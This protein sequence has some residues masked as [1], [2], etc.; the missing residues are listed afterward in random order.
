MPLEQ[1]LTTG[2]DLTFAL[3]V[4]SYGTV[5]LLPASPTTPLSAMFEQAVEHKGLDGVHPPGPDL[6]D[7]WDTV[8]IKLD[9]SGRDA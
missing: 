6:P 7:G 3:V 5:T 8:S 9:R 2:R 4:P 1:S